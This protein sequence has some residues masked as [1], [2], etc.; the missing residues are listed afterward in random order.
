MKAYIKEILHERNQ[1]PENQYQAFSEKIC[2]SVLK[3]N[4]YQECDNLLIFYPYL[5]EVNVLN[6]AE[7]AILRRK[8]VFFPKVT[9]DTTMDF[10]EVSALDDFDKGYKGILEPLG[11]ALFDK[12]NILTKTVMILPG[13][14]FDYNGNRAGYGK[15]YYDR[16]LEGCHT[17]ITKVG[18]CFSLQMLKH[19]PDVKATDIPMD[20][21]INEEMTVR[22]S[23]NGIFK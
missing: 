7:N 3:L 18:V 2:E 6:I 20:Y 19:L 17:K 8:R 9:G 13:S 22:R 4:E 11:T 14:A 21:V 12:Q 15:G 23:K 16:Y 10:I 5:G 1:I